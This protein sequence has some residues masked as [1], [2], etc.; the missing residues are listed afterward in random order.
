MERKK[1]RGKEGEIELAE[2]CM[3]EISV[4]PSSACSYWL[5]LVTPLVSHCRGEGGGFMRAHT[6]THTIPQDFRVS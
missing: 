1:E 3:S 6:H 4:F 2:K 5:A